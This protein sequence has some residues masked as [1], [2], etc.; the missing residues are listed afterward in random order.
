MAAVTI[1]SDFGAQ[2]NEICH[3]FH[4]F[5]I[6]LPWSDNSLTKDQTL[7]PSI[8]RIL[9]HWTS[10][11]V[12]APH[13]LFPPT[14]HPTKSAHLHISL[15]IPQ[16][17]LRLTGC[18]ALCSV[19]FVSEAMHGSWNLTYP[20]RDRTYTLCSGIGVSAAENYC[21]LSDLHIISCFNPQITLQVKAVAIPILQMRKLS[22]KEVTQL[23]Q[24]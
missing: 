7:F 12:L 3:C 11:E 18:Q 13:L 22:P 1:C 17:L 9:N 20:N 16:A 21:V 8:A 24:L 23:A 5:P 15:S 19:C 6:Y 2:E 4:C 10:R 14:Y